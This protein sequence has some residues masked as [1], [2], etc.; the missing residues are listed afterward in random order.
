MATA[1][2]PRAVPIIVSWCSSASRCLSNTDIK[3]RSAKAF[4]LLPGLRGP[5]LDAA[6]DAAWIALQ[7]V[8]DRSGDVL[9]GAFPVGALG[10]VAARKPRRDGAGHHVAD[11]D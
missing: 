3:G 5:D 4:A 8:D 11:A 9:R 2:R 6:R 10:L 1:S 7:Q